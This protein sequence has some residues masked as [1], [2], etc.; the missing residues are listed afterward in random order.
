MSHDRATR[1][2]F[3]KLGLSNVDALEL[4]LCLTFVQRTFIF[5]TRKFE[6]NQLARSAYLGVF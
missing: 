6:F 4:L 2:S 3:D 1:S 5:L